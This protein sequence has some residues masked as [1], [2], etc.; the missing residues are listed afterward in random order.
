V[1]EQRETDHVFGFTYV[2]LQGHAEKAVARFFITR[3]R[4]TPAANV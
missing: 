2:T 1:F 3:I 4:R